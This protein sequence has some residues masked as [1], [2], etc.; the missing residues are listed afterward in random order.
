MSAPEDRLVA[1]ETV[2][3]QHERTI[4]ELSA[5]LAE[6]WKVIDR[7]QGKLDAVTQRFLALEQQNAPEIPVTR[8]PHW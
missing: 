2:V 1:L 7:L 6:Q 8:P 5:Q 4:D 3:T